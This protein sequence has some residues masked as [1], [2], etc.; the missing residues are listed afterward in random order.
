MTNNT[1]AEK[2]FNAYREFR[3][4]EEHVSDMLFESIHL[5]MNMTINTHAEFIEKWFVD[6]I[7]FDEYDNSFEF[8]GVKIGWEPDEDMIKRWWA[9]GFS[10]CWI[11]Y[12]DGTEKYYVSPE[13]VQEY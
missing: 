12:K 3:T 10:R 8:K 7:I 9:L 2:M 11:C 5:D 6:D 4:Q 1:P 13:A